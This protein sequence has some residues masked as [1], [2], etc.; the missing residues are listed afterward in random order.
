M[1]MLKKTHEKI[2]G[3][4]VDSHNKEIES[5]TKKFE[6]I[7]NDYKKQLQENEDNF[8]KKNEKLRNEITDLKG[9]LQMKEKELS[10][11][12]DKVLNLQHKIGGL[13][14]QANRATELNNENKELKKLL[15]IAEKEIT[16][17][18][19]PTNVETR[20][21]VM[22]VEKG[23]LVDHERKQKKEHLK[24]VAKQ[25]NERR[26]ALKRKEYEKRLNKALETPVQMTRVEKN[27]YIVTEQN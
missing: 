5:K 16:E 23:K 7:E 17:Y 15:D 1:I 4:M 8:L 11:I 14:R 12:H 13:T 26:A 9:I 21:S 2:L 22:K 18:I 10:E 19:K 6:K 25:I 27:K 24:S 20:F 3:E